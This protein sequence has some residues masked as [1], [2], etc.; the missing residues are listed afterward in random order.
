MDGW[1][2]GRTGGGKAELPEVES[3]ILTLAAG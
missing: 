2:D 1:E 3:Q